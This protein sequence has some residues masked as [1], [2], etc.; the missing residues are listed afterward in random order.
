[1]LGVRTVCR[2]WRLEALGMAVTDG[3][4]GART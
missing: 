3:T 2:I 1:M 4:L